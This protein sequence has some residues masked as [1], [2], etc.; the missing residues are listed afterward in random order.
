M[1]C[2]SKL[3]QSKQVSKFKNQKQKSVKYMQYTWGQKT[4][5]G[6]TVQI[7]KGQKILNMFPIPASFIREDT[8]VTAATFQINRHQIRD[9]DCQ[10]DNIKWSTGLFSPS[11]LDILSFPAC[12]FAAAFIAAKAKSW[13]TFH[14]HG[15]LECPMQIVALK[16]F[17]Q[18]GA[19]LLRNPGRPWKS[20]VSTICT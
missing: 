8:P 15:A 4:S 20:A 1:Y 10:H 16:M 13:S 11:K 14:H 7:Q 5:K 17:S 18:D 2:R 9:V 3:R 19:K 6:H 12:Q